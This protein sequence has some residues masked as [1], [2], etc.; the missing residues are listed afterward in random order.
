MIATCAI[1]RACLTYGR[2]RSV[3]PRLRPLWVLAAQKRR[4]EQIAEKNIPLGAR[5]ASVRSILN[6]CAAASEKQILCRSRDFTFSH[7]Q[8]QNRKCSSRADVFCFTPESGHPADRPRCRFSANSGLMHRS[9]ISFYS[10][11]SSARAS[12]VGGTSRPSALA[13]SALITN[14]N[15]LACS[16]GKSAGL[17]PLRMRP[18]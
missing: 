16:T 4:A 17:A 18:A 2:A 12:S 9:K 13:V 10:I 1:S 3:P 6:C 7:S 14:S 8:G 11:T 15:L 5:S